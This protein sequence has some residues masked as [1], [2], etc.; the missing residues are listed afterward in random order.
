MRSTNKVAIKG[1]FNVDNVFSTCGQQEAQ[2]DR[3][4][5]PN[6][7][8]NWNTFC[9]AVDE[10]LKPVT[11]AKKIYKVTGGLTYFFIFG[12]IALNLISNGLI[13]M[14]GSVLSKILPV[15]FLP[16]I[17]FFLYV[18]CVVRSKLI[19]AKTAVERICSQN[20]GNGVRYTLINEH[21]GGCN[22][23]RECITCYQLMSHASRHE[24]FNSN[25]FHIPYP[26]F[27]F[28]YYKNIRQLPASCQKIFHPGKDRYNFG[29]RKSSIRS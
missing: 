15:V 24:M 6:P 18:W 5:L 7:P 4:T 2:V 13:S 28:M 19:K 17:I 27:Y 23:V 10:A 9:D 14:E 22:K 21:W 11:A 8:R 20:S 25:A 29:C 3:G 12:F 26:Y 1:Q 16:S